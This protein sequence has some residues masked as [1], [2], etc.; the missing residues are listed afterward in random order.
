MLVVALRVVWAERFRHATMRWDASVKEGWFWAV[1]VICARE[2]G[3]PP[4]RVAKIEARWKCAWNVE[5]RSWMGVDVK[6]WG[7]WW[8]VVSQFDEVE[9]LGPSLYRRCFF[10]F[11]A[12]DMITGCAGKTCMVNGML[13]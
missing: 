7:S 11:E 3:L 5:L 10:G 1:F 13:I 12:L 2:V 8:V 6:I 9:T 4:L